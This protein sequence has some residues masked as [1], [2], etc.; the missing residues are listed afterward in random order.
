M[1]VFAGYSIIAGLLLN[2]VIVKFSTEDFQLLSEE[3]FKFKLIN[4]LLFLLGS[5][6]IITIKYL[7]I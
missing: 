4:N 5:S 1:L 2:T 6:L 3:S 7:M